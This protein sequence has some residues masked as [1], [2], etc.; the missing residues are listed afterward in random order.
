MYN[1]AYMS[2]Q[3]FWCLSARVRELIMHKYP[4]RV[5]F[6]FYRGVCTWEC[7]DNPNVAAKRIR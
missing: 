1:I 2:G 7:E 3:V 5:Y 4:R 6:C